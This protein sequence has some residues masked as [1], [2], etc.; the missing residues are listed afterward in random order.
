MQEAPDP[1]D[2]SAE[3]ARSTALGR[4][5]P[6]GKSGVATELFISHENVGYLGG[7][8]LVFILIPTFFYLL[9][10]LYNEQTQTTIFQTL[11]LCIR[12]VAVVGILSPARSTDR[13]LSQSPPSVGWRR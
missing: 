4:L 6:F 10:L 11:T 12:V 1:A 9:S 13:R 2:A 8:L 3:H 7:Y 5:R